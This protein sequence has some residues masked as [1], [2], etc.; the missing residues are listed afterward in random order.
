MGE[1]SE[2]FD[3]DYVDGGI[4]IVEYIGEEDCVEIPEDIEGVPVTAIGD[5]AFWRKKLRRITIPSGVTAIGYDAFYKCG[6]IEGVYLSDIANWCKIAFDDEDANPLSMAKSVYL[7]GKPLVDLAIP[8]GVESV[9]DYAFWGCKGIK[10]VSVPKSLKRVG[11]CAFG[12]CDG[13]ERIYIEDVA[14]WCKIEFSDPVANPLI[15]AKNLYLNGKLAED[16]TIPDNVE[17]IGE[18]A[19]FHCDSLTGLTIPESVERIAQEAFFICGNLTRLTLK[20]G[21]KS[22]G[23]RAFYGCMLKDVLL[24]DGVEKLGTGAFSSCRILQSIFIPSSVTHIGAGTFSGS[25]D[26]TIYCEAKSKGAN[27]D[28]DWNCGGKVVWGAQKR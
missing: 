26:L 25:D 7:K 22:F 27:W 15:Y 24:P 2:I 11:Q 10:S 16:L 19:F 20:K 4:K 14:S 23:D 12:G 21:V 1:F 17:S 8:N 13:L 3:Y 9:G 28:E 18:F 5:G 6:E